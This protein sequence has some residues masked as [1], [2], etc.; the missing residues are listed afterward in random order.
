MNLIIITKNYE[1]A[2]HAQNYRFF[3][4]KLCLNYLIQLYH[5]KP[6]LFHDKL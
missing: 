2:V 4:K 6:G 3:W 5:S 1:K